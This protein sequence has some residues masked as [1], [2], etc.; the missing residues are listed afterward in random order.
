MSNLQKTETPAAVDYSTHNSYDWNKIEKIGKALSSRDR[1]RI[2]QI[3]AR[4][5]MN[6]Y[7]LSVNL[8]IPFSSVHK[9]IQSLSA[10]G[11]VIVDYKPTQKRHEKVC[12]IAMLAV[13]IG[14]ICPFYDDPQTFSVEMPI[15]MYRD[16]A[17]TPPCG[18]LSAE[19][20]LGPF[21]HPSVFYGPDTSS[22][23]LLWF[24]QGYVAYRFP[25]ERSNDPIE[26]IS[27]S[28][29]LC[30]ETMYYNNEWKSDIFIEINGLHCVTIHS[31]GD[32]GGRCGNFSPEFW[33]LTNTQ[34][35][36]LYTVTVNKEGVYLDKTLRTSR[37][38]IDDLKLDEK[39]FVDLKIGV[40]DDAEHV[41][42]MN[43]FGKN[44]GDYNQA[45]V[46]TIK[47]QNT[48]LRPI[49]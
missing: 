38:T 32:Y 19:G 49:K 3:L 39:P 23:E 48:P 18:M 31:L 13:T 2:L 15:G 1:I 28:F 33:D 14:F 47:Y 22:A 9:H 42:G 17:I 10:A 4:Q 21:D 35:G 24:S 11:L 26:A 8:A 30:S 44:F 16:C 12:A 6:L 20:K 29:E 34:F 25:H 46:M 37:L 5:P 41:G 45:I 7:E 36:R 27:F 40:K 43:L